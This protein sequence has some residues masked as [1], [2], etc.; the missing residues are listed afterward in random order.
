[1]KE[2]NKIKI[3]ITIGDMNGVAPEIIL[4][5]FLDKR[6]LDFCTPIIYASSKSLDF[7]NNHFID[8]EI[9]NYIYTFINL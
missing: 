9:S 6:M 4:K 7:F 2:N 3:G 8:K 1:M 5:S